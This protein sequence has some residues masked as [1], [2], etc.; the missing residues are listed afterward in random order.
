MASMRGLY[1]GSPNRFRRVQSETIALETSRTS[2][3]WSS[4]LNRIL[5]KRRNRFLCSA[6][7]VKRLVGAGML[8]FPLGMSALQHPSRFRISSCYSQ[9]QG[10]TVG[11]CLGCFSGKR[12]LGIDW[13]YLFRFLLP[14]ELPKCAGFSLWFILVRC[15]SSFS[16]F[17]ILGSGFATF[18]L[19][20]HRNF[21]M[22]HTRIRV[23][24]WLI[25][26][27]SKTMRTRP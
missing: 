26:W 7:T 23:Y 25:Y 1:N 14:V 15:Q 12:M 16:R 18:D 3:S 27:S 9:S 24:D 13:L 19:S 8:L 2:E 20:R 11:C 17:M 21:E 22:L 6:S 5:M 4:D 10:C